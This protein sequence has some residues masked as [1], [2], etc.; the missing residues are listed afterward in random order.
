MRP[1][2]NPAAVQVLEVPTVPVKADALA[3]WLGLP[4]APEMLNMLLATATEM[5]IKYLNSA[6]VAQRYRLTMDTVPR[7]T[8]RR[9]GLAS[10]DGRTSPW[11]DLPYTRLLAVLSVTR[12]DS[13]GAETVLVEGSGYRVD[14]TSKP[15][16]V[17]LLSLPGDY[18]FGALTIE[19]RAGFDD[20]ISEW[21]SDLDS[22]DYSFI[23]APIRQG[24]L[25]HAAY[26][27][28][29]RGQCDADE[30]MKKSGA[31]GLYGPFRVRWGL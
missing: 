17:E 11:I 29:H 5:A 13:A 19:Y 2:P 16:R 25:Q 24:I 1:W 4:D 28:E 9:G 20:G 30:A 27:Y 10:S 8:P 31:A 12:T 21:E 3:D 18:H 15:G 14:L 6:L 26:M 22:G 23:P 7:D